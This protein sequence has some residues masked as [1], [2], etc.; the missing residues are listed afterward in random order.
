MTF[1]VFAHK[2][3]VRFTRHVA[4][5]WR[6]LAD[7]PLGNTVCALRSASPEHGDRSRGNGKGARTP[8]VRR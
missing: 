8:R 1:L 6:R 7:A 2:P 3:A 5:V 4:L